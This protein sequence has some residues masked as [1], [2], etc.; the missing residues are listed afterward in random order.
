MNISKAFLIVGAVYLVIGMSLGIW[1]GAN[2]AFGLAPVHAHVNLVGFTLMTLF[3]L[4]YRVI[5]AL[6][7]TL[8][9]RLHFWLFQLGG[10]VLLLALYLLVSDTLPGATIGPVLALSELVVLV[11]VLAFLANLFRAA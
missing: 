2:E 4:A 1:M 5:P 7:T 11:S 6:G 8:F 3:G 10:A 9:G